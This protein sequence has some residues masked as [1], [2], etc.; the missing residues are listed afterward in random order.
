[1]KVQGR[2]H[3]GAIPYEAVIDPSKGALCRCSDFSW[4]MNLETIPKIDRQ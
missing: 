3:C 4:T 1:M 2:C